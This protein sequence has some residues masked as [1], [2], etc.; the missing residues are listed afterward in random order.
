GEAS[1]RADMRYLMSLAGGRPVIEYCGG[2]E[3]GGGYITGTVVQPCV[4]AAF[5]TPALGIDTIILDEAGEEADVGEIFLVPP[6]IGFSAELLNRDH[7]EEYYAATPPGPHGEQLR[8]HGDYFTHLEGPYFRASGRVDDTMNL[9]GIK[10]SSAEI[11]RIAIG[12][13]GIRDAAAI[14]VPIQGGGPSKLIVYVVGE[15]DADLGDVKDEVTA[16]IRTQLN[17]LFKVHSVIPIDELPRTASNKV[18]RRELRTHYLE[19]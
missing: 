5:S 14:S 10:V 16:A 1:N 13:E 2:T 15:T 6:S 11:E 17:P 18:K 3:L 19:G 9:G 8:R 7:D 12:L 4:P